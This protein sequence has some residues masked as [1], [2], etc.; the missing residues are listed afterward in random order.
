MENNE[1]IINEETTENLGTKVLDKAKA[2]W[3][4]ARGPIIG[5]AIGLA[6]GILGF[7]VAEKA[8]S[9]RSAEEPEAEEA[10]AENDVPFD[11]DK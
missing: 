6:I 5:G 8:F 9:K 7:P 10:V 1:N 4:N 2:F 3:A 11:E